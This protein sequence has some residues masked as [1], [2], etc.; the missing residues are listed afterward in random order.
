MAATGPAPLIRLTRVSRSF[1]A[2]DQTATVLDGVT[3]D[4]QPG[5][6]IAIMGASGSGKSTLMNI[7]GLLDRPSS[8]SYRFAGQDVSALGENDRAR[9]RREHFGFIFQRYQL[10]PDLDAL[11]NVEVPAV[12]RGTAR[13]RR[14]DSAAAIL[15]QLGLSDRLS[16]RP[17]QLSGGQ[18]Q[19]VSVARALMN[20][21]EV[22]LADEPTGAL[23]SKSGA[24]LI[25]LLTA[26]NRKGH[27]VIIVTHDPKIAEQTDRIVEIRDG[28]ILSDTRKV[29]AAASNRMSAAET[30]RDGPIAG[31]DRAREATGMA[32]KAMAAHRLRSFLTMLGII[33]GIAAVVSVVA[34]GTGSKEQVLRDI[35][36]IGSNTIDI[37]PGSGFGDR[38]AG[39]I[40]TLGPDDAEAIAQQ[41]YAVSVSPEVTTSATVKRGS[42]SSSARVRGVGMGYFDFG[43]FSTEAGKVFDPDDITRREQVAVID[44]EAQKVLFPDGSDPLGQTILVGRVP[45]RVIGLVSESGIGFG[46]QSIGVY[47]P[48]TTVATRITG[49]TDIDA[50]SVRIA[51]DYDMA[52]AESLITDLMLGRNGKQDFFLTNSDTLRDTIT[53]TTRTLTVLVTSIAVISLI[54]GGVGVMNIML[55]SV[56][57]R[58]REIGV[59]M[60][61]GARRS[62]IVT[63]FLIE[64]VLVSLAGGVIGVIL[65]VAGGEV[66]KSF[67]PAFPLVYSPMVAVT[68]F[69]ACCGI[70]IIFGY[71]PARTASRLDPVAALARE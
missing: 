51:D 64:A 42:A 38:R 46:P 45:A 23:D 69:I 17:S 4:I 24:D 1:A 31:L 61:V 57:E 40:K 9:L 28:R 52:V 30:G 36:R 27:T 25:A 55:V 60:S 14:R 48:Y 22:I 13:R 62:D 50:I 37:R 49:Q 56:T 32:I 41:P 44:T 18:Q 35:A 58:T 12:Y 67:F 2:G 47:L 54:V 33:I 20:G 15:T 59:R 34:L 10:L 66:A 63:Q 8:G 6:F 11:A 70:G 39:A 21:G 26:L 16:H 5:E 43:A 68:A 3:L 65:A 53:T 29:A 71:L 19:R 7:L